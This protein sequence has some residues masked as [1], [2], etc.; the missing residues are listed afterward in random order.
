MNILKLMFIYRWIFVFFFLCW[1]LVYLFYN[2]Y[3][4]VVYIIEYVLEELVFLGFVEE[5][6]CGFGIVLRLENRG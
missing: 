3:R 1:R 4:V 5:G 6:F 2:D